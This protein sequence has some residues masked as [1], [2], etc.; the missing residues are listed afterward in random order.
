MLRWAKYELDRRRLQQARKAIP[1]VTCSLPLGYCRNLGELVP[2]KGGIISSSLSLIEGNRILPITPRDGC[3]RPGSN[4]SMTTFDL[5]LPSTACQHSVVCYYR[6][7]N[8][9]FKMRK[10]IICHYL[11]LPSCV[12]LPQNG[13]WKYGDGEAAADKSQGS[14]SV[15]KDSG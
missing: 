13:L 3:V 6:I 4:T 1:A 5:C 10:N 2:V 8:L 7:S 15:G 11:P 14:H 9:D 12:A